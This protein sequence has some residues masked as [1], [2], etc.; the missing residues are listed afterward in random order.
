MAGCLEYY[1]RFLELTV[2]KKDNDD[3]DPSGI[4]GYGIYKFCGS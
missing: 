4:S 3:K 2:K 1:D